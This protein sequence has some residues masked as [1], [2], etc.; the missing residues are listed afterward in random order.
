MDRG[1]LVVEGRNEEQRENL[2]QRCVEWLVVVDVSMRKTGARRKALGEERFKKEVKPIE[3]RSCR[4]ERKENWIAEVGDDVYKM[5][6]GYGNTTRNCKGKGVCAQCG[7]E[8]RSGEGKEKKWV[9]L[10]CEREGAK[11]KAYSTMDFNSPQYQTTLAIEK[12]WGGGGRGGEDL[13]RE[14]ANTEKACRCAV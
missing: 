12:Q 10:I 7:G 6:C 13:G 14:K 1:D 2:K 11:P 3:V 9:C 8:H 4:D 5:C